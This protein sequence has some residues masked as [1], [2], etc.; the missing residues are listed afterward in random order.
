M[1]GITG[2]KG[3]GWEL[4]N[5]CACLAQVLAAAVFGYEWSLSLLFLGSSNTFPSSCPLRLLD[6]N[7]F[8]LLIIPRFFTNC[9]L[10][11]LTFPH[12][13]NGLF[14]EL[15]SDKFFVA[16]IHQKT[17]QWSDVTGTGSTKRQ[18][19]RQQQPGDTSL[20]GLCWISSRVL[21]PITPVPLLCSPEPRGG[22]CSL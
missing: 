2:S 14:T 5:A 3:W 17:Q 11:P 1:E 7:C 10:V 6:G 19:R 9:L 16:Y 13:V 12:L 22:S 15:S 20:R 21:S 8:L 4:P 18:R